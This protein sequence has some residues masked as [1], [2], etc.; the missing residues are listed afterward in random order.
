METIIING[1]VFSLCTGDNGSH[2]PVYVPGHFRALCPLCAARQEAEDAE[3]QAEKDA[4][5]NDTE[6]QKHIGRLEDKLIKY[7][8]D[9]AALAD[10]AAALVEAAKDALK[11]I[12]TVL[13]DG[14][15]TAEAERLAAAIQQIEKRQK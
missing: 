14:D 11:L 10:D 1:E 6:H 2:P 4:D 8:E 3:F 7:R 9:L 5:F 15:A 13:E 12:G